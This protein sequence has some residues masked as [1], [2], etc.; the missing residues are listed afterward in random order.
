MKH[1]CLD[2]KISKYYVSMLNQHKIHNLFECY[3]NSIDSKMYEAIVV[4]IEEVIKYLIEFYD[5]EKIPNIIIFIYPDLEMMNMAF[6]RKLPSDQCC[7][8]PVK[9]NNSLITFT[10]KIGLG[11][12]KQVL[13]HEISHIIF[14]LVSG[15][16]EINDIQQTIPVWLDEGI[17][18]F[19][20]S[21]Y[22][23]NMDEI[24][25]NRLNY[26]MSAGIECIPSLSSLYTYFNKID[27]D[28]E[29]GPNGTIAYAYSYFCV[30]SLIDK[31]GENEIVKYIKLLLNNK[32]NFELCFKKFF[33]ISINDFEN[34][35]KRMILSNDTIS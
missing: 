31:F 29:F 13:T 34:E 26:L 22:R 33:G 7:F 14:T 21:R 20:D 1:Y 18:L 2:V 23:L 3:Y 6:K 17:S 5:V 11:C 9:G 16:K 28:I 12:L 35:M 24:K 27:K 15:N 25:T 30:T 8:V 10:S 32:N 19:L 4:N